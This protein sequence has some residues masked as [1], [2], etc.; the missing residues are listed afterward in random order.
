V[1]DFGD[2]QSGLRAAR[3]AAAAARLEAW[4]AGESQRAAQA[5]LD[6]ALP[7]DP[8]RPEL[9]HA[10]REATQV[11]QSTA[12]AASK[13]V[14]V[15]QASLAAFAG[16]SD[17]RQ[18][19]G[20]LPDR[21]PIAMLP[22]RIETRFVNAGNAEVARHQLWV[23][24]YP[25]DCSIDTFEPT[26]SDA[27]VANAKLYWQGIWK[28]AGRDALRRAAWAGL[29]AAHGSG[30]A[31]YVADQ[32]QPVNPADEP[33]GAA[34]TDEV[35]VIATQTPLAGAEAAA[36]GDYW[37]AVW[38]AG[39]DGTK[40]DQAAAALDAAVGSARATELQADYVPF[41]LADVPTAPATPQTVAVT[42]AFVAFG[43][44]P[45]P[46]ASSWSQ[47]PHVAQFP[48]RFVVLGFTGETQTLEA[49]GSPVQTPLYVAPDPAADPADGIHPDGAG[50]L[51][52]PDELQWLVDFE[53]AVADGVG[54]AIDLTPEQAAAGFDRLLV[55]GVQM[56]VTDAGGQT[57][58]TEL[59]GHHQIGA[60]GLSLVPQGTPAHNTSGNGTGYH[61]LD[62][63]DESYDDRVNAPLFTV[64]TDATA[65]RDGQRLAEALGID[66][67]T[68]TTV[69]AAGGQ[70][71]LQARAMSRVLWPA[72]LGYWMDKMLAPVFSDET[73]ARTRAFFTAHVAGQGIVPAIAIGDQPYGVLP[74]TAFSRISVKA[75]VVTRESP[76]ARFLAR[77]LE[78]LRAVAADW[79][80]MSAGAS[81]VG[82]AGDPHQILLDVVG[83]HADSAEYHW[84][85]SEALTELF[86]I[87]S[88][89]GLG[90]EFWQALVELGLQEAGA[91]LLA[92]LGYGD[93]PQPDILEHVFMAQAGAIG[94]IVDD[95]PTSET[96]P[97]R[98]YTDDGRNYLAWL[99][100]AAATSL[101]TVV[102]EDGFT[103]GVSPQALLYLFL[104]HAI[105]LG[106][107]DTSYELHRSAGF[108]SET[109][110]AAMKPEPKF[111]HV[112]PAAA[113]SESRYAALY[114]VEPQITTS[115]SLLVHE[116]IA[117]ELAVLPEAAG[118]ADQIAALKT[119]QG[120]ST[121][122]LERAFAA[123][124]DT[125]SY[126]LDAWLLGLVSHQLEAMRA[127]Q[128]LG[129]YLGAYG[130]LEDLRPS[131]AQLDP[132][133]LP[134]DLEATFG[135]GAPL[136]HDETNGG[137]VHAPSLAH[138]RTAAVLRSG[139]LADASADNPGTL[140]VNLSS[141][142]VRAALS[143]LEGIRG[144]QSLG[145][146]LGYRF[147]RGLHD[148]H[149]LAEVDQFIYP[150]R[151][152]FPLVADAIAATQTAPG[153]P[154]EAIE[155][156]N[157]LDGRKLVAHIRD[158]ASAAYPF[159]IADL[160]SATPAAGAAIDAEV[161]AML[162]VYDAIADLALAEGV[163]QAV[164]GSFDRV[165]ATL[166]AY[167]TGNFPP[168]PEVVQTPASG[169]G[170]THRVAL[171]LQ[172]GLAAPA[173]AT[174]R[175][176]AE[177]AIDRWLASVL[178]ALNEVGCVVAWT[179]PV[180][181]GART[182]DV[183]LD[184]LGLHPLDLLELVKPDD[185][186][187]MAELDDR[188]LGHVHATAAP[189]PDATLQ[190]HYQQAPAGG[191]AIFEVGAL[192]RSLRTLVQRSRPLRATDAILHN[193]ARPADDAAVSADRSRVGDPFVA[194]QTL[195]GDVD[196]ALTPLQALLAAPDVNRDALVSGVDA[197][198]DTA[199]ALLER[200][201]RFGVPQSGWGFT[202]EWRRG[203]LRDLLADVQTLVDSWDA[204]LADVQAMLNAYDALPFAT[205][206]ATRFAA[207]QAAE[208]RITVSLD[209]LPPDPGTLRT[210]LDTKRGAVATVRNAWA[211]IPTSGFATFAAA[212]AAVQ[213]APSAAAFD[214]AP[215]D[216][217]P[218]G[219]RALSVAGQVASAL[220][221]HL[222][223]L[224][225]R[226]T[227]TGTALTA[228]DAATSPA[229]AVQALQTA[230]QALLGESFTL[231]P[232][233][234][235][236]APQAA[237]WASAVAGSQTGNLLTYLTDTAKIEQPVDEWLYGAA[238]VR[239]MLA[240]WE[241]TLVL[242][243]AFGLTEPD[244]VPAQ[245]PFDATASWLAMQSPDAQ[246]TTSD[247]L[248]Y[249]AHYATAFDGTVAQCG[250]LLD[251]WTEVIP[252]TT[253]DT[254]VTFNFDRPDS[255]PA[256]SI[257]LV[258]PA[259]GDGVWHWDDVVGALN[260]TLD[261]AKMRAVEPV[262]VD[263]TP[264]AR[265]LPATI[266]AATLH[267][268]TISTMLAVT[269]NVL[270]AQE[271]AARA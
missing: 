113:A 174:P 94:L 201:A 35:L 17:P 211:A 248:L 4:Q 230:A 216:L 189:R 159:G 51:T 238:R 40:L 150:L 90:P 82:A 7:D 208:A 145:A 123:H 54:L 85:Y 144:G 89:W 69:H 68:L 164:Q 19:I 262:H 39:D 33:A 259:T 192:L 225:Q 240:A 120:A 130:W 13:A 27:E 255:E 31:A 136:R 92:Q 155:A 12:A 236:A 118:L 2:A 265:F 154:I 176:T 42:T 18:E 161:N 119:L 107:Y 187:A 131:T 204:R 197:T 112:D 210:S 156:R 266:M 162:D 253:K 177:P 217:T 3:A 115:P 170:L 116:Y 99:A 105:Q 108:L 142:R 77:L 22:V 202:Y 196:A 228:H 50:G 149:A 34:A 214:P 205:D 182:A 229:A 103:G 91:G 104:R 268:I 173:G 38:K 141:D 125:C 258:T 80:A 71:G 198:L 53:R 263:Q 239:P 168:D 179:D 41:N 84:R 93:G 261:L 242:A 46:K 215:L 222:A 181:G 226:V 220:T 252:A 157:V 73:V 134:D 133:R 106:Y 11:A 250:L 180:G 56:S 110:L 58:L 28:A 153:V 24:V 62:D 63:A 81:H 167:T 78:L 121:A 8:R 267:G 102:A 139:Y 249:T 160:P 257:L 183:T 10:R 109:E 221:G 52:V 190:I 260:E 61:R 186:A 26:L 29:V 200:A 213:G 151:K 194:L 101:Q 43:A 124:I 88:M 132:V 76:D 244:L 218:Y 191:R 212:L 178:P 237:E 86:N 166:D 206:N 32:F 117:A 126:R 74:T 37:V 65:K 25:D 188:I 172:S 232:E 14:E 246:T 270:A 169:I 147:E 241:Q 223:A 158:G 231:V 9:E 254:G 163:H 15:S 203:A 140:S 128:P 16:F 5:A 36:T 184:D 234:T 97:V 251:E 100:D 171:H 219:D 1:S 209:P 135:S 264:Y 98:A 227:D 20:R 49:I 137:Y 95:R 224:N 6:A 64:T 21:S 55:L 23:R 199:A 175:A 185:V 269:D 143:V 193:D 59:L 245:F 129:V 243:G 67:A 127:A 72:T 152:A 60:S 195:A 66:P 70:D 247:R 30:R 235:L 148:D 122:E 138:A 87:I 57:A 45:P 111:I 146:L 114:K 79:R 48:E 44:D 47:A 165:G 96:D 256:Q 75:P 207:L 271:I 83:L 233:F